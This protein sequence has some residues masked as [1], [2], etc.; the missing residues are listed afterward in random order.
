MIF[1]H[2]VAGIPPMIPATMNYFSI[3]NII[4][5]FENLDV[6][7]L[8]AWNVFHLFSCAALNF[9][10]IYFHLFLIIVSIEIIAYNVVLV[11][12]EIY[13]L[14]YS[15]KSLKGQNNKTMLMHRQLIISIL[16]QVKEFTKN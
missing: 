1:L 8:Y 12:T 2:V 16:L 9:S 4:D 14:N 7:Y 10:T 5:S 11:G 6:K 3:N 15:I 13:M